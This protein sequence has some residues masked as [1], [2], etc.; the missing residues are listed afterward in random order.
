MKSVFAV[1]LAVAVAVGPVRAAE[2]TTR[3]KVGR[4]VLTFYWIVDESASRYDGKRSAELRDT[5][6]RLIA[7]STR[8]FRRDLVMEG[9]GWLRDGRTVTYAGKVGG[10][11]RFRIVRSRWGLTASGCPPDPYRSAAVDPNFV[12]LGSKIYIPQLKGTILPDGTKHDGVFI[13]NDRGHFRGAHVD[14]FVG[15]G[16]RAT[17]PFIRR[18]YRSRSFITV[19]LEGTRV[20]RCRG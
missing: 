15:V 8:T 1:A 4:A 16:P 7:N 19:Y 5:R 6:G 14:V 17:R 3:E 13:A 2:E 9:T 18:G 11:H 12:K 20:P 10:E